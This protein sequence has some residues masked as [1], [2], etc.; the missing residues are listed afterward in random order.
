MNDYIDMPNQSTEIVVVS[1]DVHTMSGT[2]DD[3]ITSEVSNDGA[4]KAFNFDEWIT[5]NNVSRKTSKLLRDQDINNMDILKLMTQQELL[6]LGVTVG[7]VKTL[8]VSLF[9]G[10]SG[11]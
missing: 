3:I 9:H 5:E 11:G 6:G 1:A 4:E 2:S 8:Y 10:S 7:Q